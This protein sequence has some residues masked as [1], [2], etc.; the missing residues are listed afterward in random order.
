MGR[1]EL[2]ID[3]PLLEALTRAAEQKHT[4]VADYVVDL[5]RVAWWRDIPHLAEIHRS[6]YDAD[7]PGE[8]EFDLDAWA[9]IQAWGD[10]D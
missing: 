10:E 5:I 7:R 6:S 9:A 2:T 8:D 1:I 3:D 4:P